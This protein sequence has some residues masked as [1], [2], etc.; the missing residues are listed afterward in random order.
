MSTRPLLVCLQ[1]TA[2]QSKQT[3]EHPLQAHVSLELISHGAYDPRSERRASR[4]LAF[5]SRL[6]QS[7]LHKIGSSL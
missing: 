2:A 5:D 7:K 4:Q 6:Q 3:L 1:I